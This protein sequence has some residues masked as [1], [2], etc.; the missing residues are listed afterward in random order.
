[1]DLNRISKVIRL[2][3]QGRKLV[4]QWVTTYYLSSSIDGIH[5]ARYRKNSRDKVRN[6]A[7]YDGLINCSVAY[8][9][10]SINPP[11]YNTPP[12]PTV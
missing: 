1:M 7:P 8:R 6:E 2:G 10:S 5:F 9:K 4:S 3:T 12:P 11:F